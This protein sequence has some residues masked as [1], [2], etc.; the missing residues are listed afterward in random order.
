ME[1]RV[2]RT[3]AQIKPNDLQQLGECQQN[4]AHSE[5]ASFNHFQFEL[6]LLI[7]KY[8]PNVQGHYTVGVESSLSSVHLRVV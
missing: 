6:L 5:V 8:L 2:I 1:A 3:V 7:Y 4:P